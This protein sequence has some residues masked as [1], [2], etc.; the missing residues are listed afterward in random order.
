MEIPDFYTG[1]Y[2]AISQDARIGLAHISLYIAL[3]QL[4]C[5]RGGQTQI[6]IKRKELMELSKIGSSATYHKCLRNLVEYGYIG[7][8]P[9]FNPA[10]KSGFR[11]LTSS[12]A[13]IKKDSVSERM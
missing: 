8:T 13:Q 1:F 10:E 7:Y 5:S 12:P 9:S 4:W 11:L 3:Y 6:L 2:G